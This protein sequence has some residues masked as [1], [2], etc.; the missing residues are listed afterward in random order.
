MLFERLKYR[1]RSMHQE[2]H[3]SGR[4]FDTFACGQKKN[5]FLH[6]FYLNSL[7]SVSHTCLM[8]LGLI[9]G[10][11]SLLRKDIEPPSLLEPGSSGS[12]VRTEH[13]VNILIG[14]CVSFNYLQ[15]HANGDFCHLLI[16]CA[17][18]SVPDQARH[19]A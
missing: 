12:A 7:S 2:G 1:G 11:M 14:K 3:Q 9:S 4:L 10:T 19:N 13:I 5:L 15:V 8:S 17:N 18:S 6:F 16:I